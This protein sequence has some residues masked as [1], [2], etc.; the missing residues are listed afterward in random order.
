MAREDFLARRRVKPLTQQHY[1]RAAAEV[2]RFADRNQ[3]RFAT[4]KQRDKLMVDYLQSIFLAGD[5]IFAART[6]LYGFAFEE[7]VNLK[8][9]SEFPQ[10]RLTLKGFSKASPGEQRDPC[11]WEAAVLIIEPCLDSPDPRQRLLGAAVAVAFDGYLRLSELLSIKG[12]DVTCLRHSATSAYPQVS[13]TLMP[14]PPPDAPA[15]AT[16]KSGEYDDTVIFG[17]GGPGTA[18]RRWV[19]KLLRDL[20]AATPATKPLFPFTAREFQL[21]FRQAANTAGL[22][23]LRLC[24]HALRHGGASADFATKAR[25]LLEVQRHGRWKCAASVRRYEK[26]G[27]LTRQLAKLSTGQLSSAALC[28][29]KLAAKSS[30]V[31]GGRASR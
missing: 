2:R 21:A 9:P 5:G 27:R 29:R 15:S 16:T 3:Y 28:S 11:P 7:R 26:A 8:D 6:A 10:A 24:P 30:F 22:Q 14:C 18:S 4:A 17:G 13:I 20:K 19:A 31:F 1:A 25:T 23:R 12:G